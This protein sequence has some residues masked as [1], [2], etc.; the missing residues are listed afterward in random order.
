MSLNAQKVGFPIARIDKGKW[1][2]ERI[3]CDD[4]DRDN[5]KIKTF[6]KLAIDKEDKGKFQLI[7][8]KEERDCLF[9][10]GP[11]GSG[12]S[13]ISAEYI[14]EYAKKNPNNDIY[15]FSNCNNDPAFEKLKIQQIKIGDNLI[16]D[17]ID[18]KQFTNCVC[19][20]DDID[21]ITPKWRTPIY[22]ILD[23]I[24]EC[25]R[26]ARVTCVLI[27]HLANA[28]LRSRRLMAES[29]IFIYFPFSATKNTT[30][31]L[32]T[33]FSVSNE[34]CKKIKSLRSRWAIIVRNIKMEN[35][36]VTEKQ[37]FLL[38]DEDLKKK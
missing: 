11:A 20:F 19:I 25:S 17:P 2:G 10:C 12:K 14:H 13:Y 1:N 31:A 29:N 26:K 16:D 32:E 30:R 6:K 3:Y 22:E 37:V 8:V 35:I 24:L 28:G 4:E 15:L 9:V 21:S 23:A 36:C 18:F 34:Q 38:E 5:P 27:Q 33:Y 7:P